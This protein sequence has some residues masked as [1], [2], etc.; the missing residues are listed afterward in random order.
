MTTSPIFPNIYCFLVGHPGI[1]KN[2]VIRAVKEYLEEVPDFHFSP[3]SMT[4][5]SLVDAL[6]SSK[7]I[8]VRMPQAPLEYNSMMITAEELTAFMHK[9]DDEMIGILSAFYDP[10]PYVQTRRG[11]EIRIKIKYPQLSILSGT[12]PS[13]LIKFLPEF[14]W[15]Q[16]FTSRVLL[17]YS[18]ER[19]IGDDFKADRMILNKDMAH[20]IKAINS[21]VGEFQVTKDFQEAV[22]NWRR[23]GEPPTPNHP[24]L[25]HYN[26]RRRVHLYK[27]S[28][29][30]SVD[31]SDSLSLTKADFDQAYNWLCEAELY[32]PEIFR[33]G[34]VGTD[35]RAMEEI[36]YFIRAADI[37]KEG[38]SEHKIVKFASEKIPA[39]T[40]MRV[41]EIMERSGTIAAIS[42]DEKTGLRKYQVKAP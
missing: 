20:D 2:R 41:L 10:D 24:K 35:A 8:I 34:S 32:M 29:V 9:Y 28:M 19:I 12:T 37:K 42:K 27:L 23:L 31:Q 22:A 25:L 26:T 13:N 15:D 21:L 3:T 40:V 4:G 17:I 5:A 18:D 33:A 38:V 6:L 1:G 30:S 7:R 14:A 16:G 11:K 36:E 39:H